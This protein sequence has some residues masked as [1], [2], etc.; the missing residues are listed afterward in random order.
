MKFITPDV[1]SISSQYK[2]SRDPNEFS[3]YHLTLSGLSES[4]QQQPQPYIYLFV[5]PSDY[6]NIN[7]NS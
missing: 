7:M 5:T 3:W 6:F 2:S 1:C 4:F